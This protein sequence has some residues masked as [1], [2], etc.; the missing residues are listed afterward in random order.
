MAS[1][2]FVVPLAQYDVSGTH[3]DERL[4]T[5]P[6]YSRTQGISGYTGNTMF[7]DA[8]TYPDLPWSGNEMY[9]VRFYGTKSAFNDIRKKDDAYGKE[10]HNISDS[11]VVTYLND[12]T[13]NNYTFTEWESLFIGSE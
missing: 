7:F 13:G 2:W 3:P 10:E 5:A 6:K 1:Q 8:Q 4:V 9:V 12:K 11:E